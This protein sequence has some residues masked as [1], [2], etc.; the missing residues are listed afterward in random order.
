MH[1]SALLT[2]TVAALAPLTVLANPVSSPES[3]DMVIEERSTL[4]VGDLLRLTNGVEGG[5]LNTEIHRADGSLIKQSDLTPA[6]L[7]QP[8]KRIEKLCI[9]LLIIP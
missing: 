1:F 4:L 6:M 8:V 3:T 5:L 9:V 7:S 2:A